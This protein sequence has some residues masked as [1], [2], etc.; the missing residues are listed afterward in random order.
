[1]ATW[2]K[3]YPLGGRIIGEVGAAY[4]FPQNPDW[5]EGQSELL[6]WDKPGIDVWARGAADGLWQ[7]YWD[8]HRWSDW[9]D[10]SN[11]GFKL[12]SSPAVMF[13]ARQN[14]TRTIFASDD[15]GFLK[16]NYW[17]GQR[18]VG[19]KPID[20]KFK[21]QVKGN[22]FATD[23]EIFGALYM[24][25]MDNRLWQ[26]AWV[27]NQWVWEGHEGDFTL[28]STPSAV[29]YSGSAIFNTDENGQVFQKYREGGGPWTEWYPLD[30]CKI[31]GDVAAIAPDENTVGLYVRSMDDILYQ[32]T[33]NGQ[34][35]TNWQEVPN[36][37]LAVSNTDCSNDDFKLDSSPTVICKGNPDD[38]D[39]VYDQI[40][41][42]ARGVDGQLWH[43]YYE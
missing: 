3:W 12:G 42:F 33:W 15:Q 14:S 19:W 8:G 20:E 13:W 36:N 24:R 21:A 29:F 26:A 2:S 5:T 30:P 9:I 18:F 39:E 17:D 4:Y 31:K 23:G 34:R 25:S 10:H 7:I 41:V 38:R 43:K 1:M 11:D 35:W 28:F 16:H 22:V 40:H 6:R 32:N 37:Y 27:S